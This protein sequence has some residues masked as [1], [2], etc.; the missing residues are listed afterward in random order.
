L[1]GV[2]VSNLKN[3]QRFAVEVDRVATAPVRYGG[4]EFGGLAG[5]PSAS[6][7]L[8]NESHSVQNAN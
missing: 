7:S 1:V 3:S 5:V 8:K 6:S 2:I 4:V